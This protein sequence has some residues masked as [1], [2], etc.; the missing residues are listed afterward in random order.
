MI[1]GK[2]QIR[3]GSLLHDYFNNYSFYVP[4]SLPAGTYRLT[5]HVKDETR[6]D[7]PR[8]ASKTLEFRVTSMSARIPLCSHPL[9]TRNG[10]SSRGA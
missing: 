5:I 1:D 4:T 7:Q 6:P 3:S 9:P 10:F 2:Q 8:E